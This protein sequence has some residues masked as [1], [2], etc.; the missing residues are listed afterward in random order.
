MCIDLNGR[1]NAT[2]QTLK[3]ISHV[4]YSTLLVPP[5]EKRNLVVCAGQFLKLIFIILN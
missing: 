2:C 1:T 4:P 5:Q 3:C